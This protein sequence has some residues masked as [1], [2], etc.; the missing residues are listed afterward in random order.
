MRELPERGV[1]NRLPP[2]PPSLDLRFSE[3]EVQRYSRHILLGE[4]GGTGLNLYRL[5]GAVIGAGGVLVIYHAV[6]GR[7]AL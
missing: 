5:I 1:K 6:A 4:V 2:S 7:R 3:H